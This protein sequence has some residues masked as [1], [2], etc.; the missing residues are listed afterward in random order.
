MVFI[1]EGISEVARGGFRTA[2][3]F[4]MELFVMI[5]YGFQLLIIITECFILDVAVVDPPMV[6][7][8]NWFE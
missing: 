2:A 7:L 5:V 3:T 8:E 4:E 1:T 6:A